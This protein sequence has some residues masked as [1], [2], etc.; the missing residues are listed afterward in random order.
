[1]KELT[2]DEIL[3]RMKEGKKTKLEPHFYLEDLVGKTIQ[4]YRQIRN[5]RK[6]DSTRESPN[7]EH[8]DILLF[9]DGTFLAT[10]N[11]GDG[12]CGHL[13]YYYYNGQETRYSDQLF[14]LL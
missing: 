3:A 4:A 6:Y 14:G 7:P 12:E 10:E 9:S 11:W 13:N 2:D 8:F 1:M 5:P